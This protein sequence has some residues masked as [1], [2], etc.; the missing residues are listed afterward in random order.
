M[1]TVL[2]DLSKACDCIPHDLLAVK[3]HAYC[4]S[5]D[6]G[7]FVHSY[8]KCRKQDV[9]IN[10]TESVFQIRCTTRFYIRPYLFNIFINDFIFFIKDVWLAYFADD[11]T[12]Y[13]TRN[14]IEEL[15]KVL[16]KE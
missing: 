7:S 4:L 8:L 10:D 14:S 9:K 5:E 1:G 16:E 2:L 15:L 13:A 11:S 3:L 12:I 6:V